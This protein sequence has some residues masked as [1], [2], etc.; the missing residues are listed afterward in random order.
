KK[1][2]GMKQFAKTH[3][4]LDIIRFA[5]QTLLKGYCRFQSAQAAISKAP[6]TARFQAKGLHGSLEVERIFV[7]CA[8]VCLCSRATRGAIN[9]AVLGLEF[10]VLG[11][12]VFREVW[13]TN[14][15]CLGHGFCRI[16]L[17]ILRSF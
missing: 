4:C 15:A 8:E 16:G 10:C 11:S 6:S 1:S 5:M 14:C 12:R 9:V 3:R 7:L 13:V 2:K 17:R